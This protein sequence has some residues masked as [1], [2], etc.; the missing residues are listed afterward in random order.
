MNNVGKSIVLTA[1]RLVLELGNKKALQSTTTGRMKAKRAR[2]RKDYQFWI[3]VASEIE[4]L[5]PISGDDG[6]KPA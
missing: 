3:A 2:S 1:Q 5:N 4:S 6:D